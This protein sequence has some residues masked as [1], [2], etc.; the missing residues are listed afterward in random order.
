MVEIYCH[1]V[2][3]LLLGRL[4]RSVTSLLFLG[5]SERRIEMYVTAVEPERNADWQDSDEITGSASSKP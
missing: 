2:V 3:I 5:D 4:T 1:R